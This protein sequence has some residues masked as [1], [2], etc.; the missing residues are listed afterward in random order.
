M[1]NALTNLAIGLITTII[2][3]CVMMNLND[4]LG[5]YSNFY[6]N[7]VNSI[8]DKDTELLIRV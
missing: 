4:Q 7:N 3:K 1:L 5:A 2:L 8:G 6:E